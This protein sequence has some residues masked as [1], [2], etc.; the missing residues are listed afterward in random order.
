MVEVTVE[1][2]IVGGQVLGLDCVIVVVTVETAG[3]VLEVWDI[4][5]ELVVETEED[6]LQ[7]VTNPPIL[8]TAHPTD[9]GV[10]VDVLLGHVLPEPVTEI[11]LVV[12]V[13]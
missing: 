7:P 13:V 12:V 9:L 1:A 5:V 11:V 6:G 8:A 2:G 3:H 10:D 4:E